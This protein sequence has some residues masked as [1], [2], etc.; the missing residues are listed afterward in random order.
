MTH[1][2]IADWSFQSCRALQFQNK[3]ARKHSQLPARPVH[4]FKT[5]RR[6]IK[7]AGISNELWQNNVNNNKKFKWLIKQQIIP[8]TAPW[9]RHQRK[10]PWNRRWD[11]LDHFWYPQQI[12]RAY[13]FG[14][15]RNGALNM[16]EFPAN[17]S[18]NSCI[19]NTDTM[20]CISYKCSAQFST[21]PKYPCLGQHSDQHDLPQ[22]HRYMCTYLTATKDELFIFIPKFLLL[23]KVLSLY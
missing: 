19:K 13:S 16:L 14:I 21:R 10:N 15:E 6:K 2:L 11:P 1:P 8:T 12:Q 7:Y 22:Y 4:L 3:T 23:L 18:E 5:I 20:L 9:I 17:V